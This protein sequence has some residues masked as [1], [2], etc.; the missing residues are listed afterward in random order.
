MSHPSVNFAPQPAW[1]SNA[2]NCV[3][4]VDGFGIQPI[5]GPRVELQKARASCV[6]EHAPS[7]VC[8]YSGAQ[9]RSCLPA[10]RKAVMSIPVQV[11]ERMLWA[12]SLEWT[13]LHM[14]Q[15]P[16]GSKS[17]RVLPPHDLNS[18]R[19]RQQKSAASDNR[20]AISRN[21]CGS[22]RLKQPQYRFS[23]CARR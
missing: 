22:S 21:V 14:E 16:R 20:I 10:S 11:R 5:A 4:T 15:T 2:Q 12:G 7:L 13:A 1:I 3:A 8:M 6:I 17:A 9:R 18:T 23:G 19:I